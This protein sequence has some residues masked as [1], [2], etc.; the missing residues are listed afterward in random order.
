M[1]LV[2]DLDADLHADE[3]V[4]FGIDGVSYEIDLTSDHAE[5]LRAQIEQWAS[6][7]RKLGSVRR[8]G[9]R[10]G[11]SGLP[12]DK[13]AQIREWGRSNGHEVGDR[14]RIP[15]ELLEAFNAAHR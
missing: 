7:A 12:K 14:G 4:E 2:D 8:A 5:Q 1:D 13:I 15:A 11:R 6:H 10:A 9:R 3:T